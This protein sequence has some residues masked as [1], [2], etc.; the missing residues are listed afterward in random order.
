MP[1]SQSVKGKAFEYACLQSVVKLLEE[2]GVSY[3]VE[4]TRDYFKALTSFESLSQ[5]EKESFEKAAITGSKQIFKLEP[6]LEYVTED[7]PLIVRLSADAEAKG[8]N[9]DV[10]DVVFI[11]KAME[12]EVGISCKHN[13]EALRHPR[14]T[15]PS[16]RKKNATETSLSESIADFGTNWLGYPCSN[17]YFSKMTVVM[18]KIADK[19]GMPWKE[20][21]PELHDDIYVPILSIIRDEIIRL[22][23]ENAD[24]PQ[25]LISYFF[26]SKDFYKV[27]S[28]ENTMSTKIMAFNMHKTLGMAYKNHKPQTPISQTPLPTRLIEI[29]FKENRTGEISKTT[30]ELVMDY[31][32]TISMRLHSADSAIK[33]TGLKFDVQ[34]VGN[35]NKIYQQQ[36]AWDED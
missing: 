23:N 35:P 29:R 11:R 14:L 18:Q 15:N 33:T 24:A 3:Q 31:G 5:E 4:E 20:A 8:A 2:K 16:A 7:T 1:S 19:V 36:R 30:L 17:E 21:F 34:L 22:C 13:H 6:H 10:R 26:G 32:W 25:K 28:L 9:G 27:I 12:W